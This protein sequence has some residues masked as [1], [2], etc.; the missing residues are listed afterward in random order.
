MF[1]EPA[2]KSMLSRKPVDTQQI[3]QFVRAARGGRSV[4]AFAEQCGTSYSTISKLENFAFSRPVRIDLL[5]SIFEHA[6]PSA[7]LDWDRMLLANGRADLI[8]IE[9]PDANSKVDHI[10]SQSLLAAGKQI[11][12]NLNVHL[13]TFSYMKRFI[14]F[15]FEYMISGDPSV[16]WFFSNLSFND[17]INT[18]SSMVEHGKLAYTNIIQTIFLLDA[19]HPDYLKDKYITFVLS[20][21]YLYSEFCRRCN[22]AKLNSPISFCLFDLN[23]EVF[24]DQYQ[25]PKRDGQKDSLFEVL[26]PL[27]EQVLQDK[28]RSSEV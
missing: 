2:R 14:Y 27:S 23:K 28:P 20:D 26:C 25:V 24:E 9:T 6:D 17:V 19:W 8:E 10:V 5:R 3:G 22:D 13:R 21:K 15:D 1:P 16:K 11:G 7:G 4:R 12:R 18:S